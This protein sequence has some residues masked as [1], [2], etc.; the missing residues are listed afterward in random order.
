LSLALL[1][2]VKA[3]THSPVNER[4]FVELP[5]GFQQQGKIGLLHQALEGLKQSANLW[6]NLLSEVLAKFGMTRSNMDPNLY[7][8]NQNGVYI[9]IVVWVDDM[10][11]G[12]NCSSTFK[13]LVT[14]METRIKLKVQ[15]LNQF[16]GIQIQRDRKKRTITLLQAQY[17][18]ALAKKHLNLEGVKPWKH[19]TPS[20]TSREEVTKYMSI[21]NATTD[22]EKK[23]I[24]SKGYLTILGALLWAACMTMPDIMFHTSHLARFMQSPSTAAYEALID[25]L[26]YTY[27]RKDIGITFGGD[28]ALPPIQITQSGMPEVWG[29]A[30]FGGSAVTPYGGG[31]IRWRNAAVAWLARK[32]KFIPLSTCEAEVAAMVNILKEAMFVIQVL[33]DMGY[34]MSDKMPVV[35]DSKSAADIVENPGVTKHTAHFSRWL[36]WARD[37]V[38]KHRIDVYLAPSEKMMADSLSKVVDRTKFFSCRKFQLNE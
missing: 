24:I 23:N 5:E 15:E 16:V 4:I 10:A 11:V 8:Y 18:E 12:H 31:F 26:K 7:I 6:Q 25:L 1:D 3:F 34:E 32:F 35:T 13:K 36:H 14:H 27:C 21:G 19:H 17:V 9:I 38:L 30:S 28:E 22:A 33:R 37:L 20:G 29:D 2:V